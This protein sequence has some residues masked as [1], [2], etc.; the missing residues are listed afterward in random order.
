L[1]GYE[2]S[3]E[4]IILTWSL[5]EFPSLSI[6]RLEVVKKPRIA[7]APPRSNSIF[8]ISFPYHR[9][10]NKTFIKNFIFEDFHV[11]SLT[12]ESKAHN[13]LVI[14]LRDTEVGIDLMKKIFYINT[15][16]A[17]FKGDFND[18]KM[19]FDF[20]EPF[21][22]EIT[23][24]H[25]RV[26]IFFSEFLEGEMICDMNQ[27][28]CRGEDLRVVIP[29]VMNGFIK[30]IHFEQVK[31]SFFPKIEAVLSQIDFALGEIIEEVSINTLENEEYQVTFPFQKKLFIHPH[32]MSFRFVDRDKN[33]LFDGLYNQYEL[34]GKGNFPLYNLAS[35]YHEKTILIE[36]INIVNFKLNFDQSCLD[37]NFVDTN[38]IQD[39]HY[40]IKKGVAHIDQQ[41]VELF[42]EQGSF[43][44]GFF[45]DVSMI[46]QSEAIAG[47]G[48]VTLEP[49]L[50]ILKNLE[51][52]MPTLNSNIV[53]SYQ[54]YQQGDDFH[55]SFKP[56]L[57]IYP[58]LNFEQLLYHEH[59]NIFQFLTKG[60]YQDDSFDCFLNL[61]SELMLKDFIC[62][63][64][65]T[66]KNNFLKVNE[67]N[68]QP[69]ILQGDCTL[70]DLRL[71]IDLNGHEIVFLP[72]IKK[73]LLTG[74]LYQGKYQIII[75]DREE[76]LSLDCSSHQHCYLDFKADLITL[77]ERFFKNPFYSHKTLPAIGD[78]MGSV[79]SLLFD[80]HVFNASIEKKHDHMTMLI[81]SDI[82]AGFINSKKNSTAIRLDFLD[83][84]WLLDKKKFFVHENEK[85]DPAMSLK[86]DLIFNC[87]DLI[88]KGRNLG[89]IAFE[90]L[91]LQD[92][93]QD[94]V[95]SFDHKNL[96]LKLQGI[97]EEN[98]I[99]GKGSLKTHSIEELLKPFLKKSLI[100]D[101]H[102]LITSEYFLGDLDK[103][104]W[105]GAF[106]I[107]LHD[108]FVADYSIKQLQILNFFSGYI[109]SKQQLRALT[110]EGFPIDQLKAH[111]ELDD[112]VLA[113]KSAHF[114]SGATEFY[115][116]GSYHMNTDD[117]DLDVTIYPKISGVLPAAALML[118]NIP[119]GLA[120]AGFTYIAGDDLNKFNQQR[121][122]LTGPI[123]DVQV[124]PWEAIVIERAITS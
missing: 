5:R 83:L 95:M 100:K 70:S 101:G 36:K 94:H 93:Y 86:K 108:L 63:V 52:Y 78:Y 61:D 106:D 47:K 113:I 77:D 116:E 31:G 65:P 2:C 118:G 115:F 67:D 89:A 37:L 107:E 27:L 11:E 96:H 81:D 51:S 85:D 21:R 120:M 10:L 25:D 111:L 80:Q 41:G 117:I 53:L 44:Y 39:Y 24:D 9:Y 112:G 97:F 92:Q 30:N 62:E 73:L 84:S 57:E 54:F 29:N 26:N 59:Q 20:K 56:Q 15:I 13:K 66:D 6:D 12:L 7:Q 16:Y 87:H 90:H 124:K 1:L 4:N 22:F 42:L 49:S 34:I 109:F 110:Q 60:S 46:K 105:K 14:N 123:N 114:K 64:K 58:D 43:D 88:W 102:C 19:N 103:K 50:A 98:I 79:K 122:R 71:K 33:I 75:P 32:Q 28:Y 76:Y 55:M 17:P 74:D 99:Q 38:V 69:I 104:T 91:Y 119:A 8:F 23:F 121:L 68:V 45:D 3:A 18:Q 82:V 72:T 48:R 40:L 35:S